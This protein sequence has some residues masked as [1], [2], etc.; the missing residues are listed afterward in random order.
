M[1]SNCLGRAS[2]HR[3]YFN[4]SEGRVWYAGITEPNSLQMRPAI[5]G[6]VL[7]LG[8]VAF[9]VLVFFIAVNCFKVYR[10]KVK[11]R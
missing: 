11:L 9:V 10:R 2:I 3:F 7:N 6:T 4:R 1:G 8:E 5:L